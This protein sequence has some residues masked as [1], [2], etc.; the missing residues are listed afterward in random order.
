MNDLPHGL[1]PEDLQSELNELDANFQVGPDI[2][3]DE[4]VRIIKYILRR[5]RGAAVGGLVSSIIT[6]P[7]FLSVPTGTAIGTVVGTLSVLNG[8]GSYTFSFLSNPG[9]YFSI[10]G[11]QIRVA[12]TLPSPQIIP[13]SIQGDN[14]LGDKPVLNTNISITTFGNAPTYYIYGF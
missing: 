2:T 5:R 10:V 1:T 13:V 8:L 12:A 4:Y 11:N 3:Y 9:G 6:T 14:G 7:A